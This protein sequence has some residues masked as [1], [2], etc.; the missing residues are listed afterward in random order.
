MFFSWF[1]DLF[2]GISTLFGSI[3]AETFFFED[4]AV[5][6]VKNYFPDVLSI[7]NKWR[8]Q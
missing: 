8:K 4:K 6:Y 2:Y 1:V 7:S 5:K 3:Y